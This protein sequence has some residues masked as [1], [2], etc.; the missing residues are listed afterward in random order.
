MSVGVTIPSNL[1]L[2]DM[3]AVLEAEEAMTPTI[4][5]DEFKFPPLKVTESID[6]G[7]FQEPGVNT[8][9]KLS[10]DPKLFGVALRKDIVHEVIR[11]Q[12]AK[13]RQPKRTKRVG[14]ISGSKKKPRP[15]KGQGLSQAGNKRNSAWRGGMKAHGPVIR[16]YS[17]SLNRKV[18]AMGMMIVLAAKMREGNLHVF[19]SIQTSSPKTK[20]L[21]K[22]LNEHNLHDTKAVYLDNDF[23]MDFALA[24][25]NVEYIHPML[26]IQA[27]V[28]D[29]VRNEKLIVSANA[30]AELQQRLMEQYT[31][32]GKRRF[33]SYQKAL[34]EEARYITEAIEKEE[35]A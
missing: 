35:E 7:K 15:Q 24:S 34:L 19:D 2:E 32:S 12:R 11:Y 17:F 33:Y 14:E 28:Y 10:L 23:N 1:H 9:E 30:L 6:I 27:N 18:R 8:G 21:V 20:D 31:Y 25:R 26:A 4:S 5:V 29:I 22:L 3:S 16:D 13:V